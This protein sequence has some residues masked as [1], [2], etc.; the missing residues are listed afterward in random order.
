[1]IRSTE[2]PDDDSRSARKRR[3]ILDSAAELFLAN[4]YLGTSLDE[5][6]AAA[7]VSKQTVYKQFTNKEALFIGVVR[8]MTGEASDLV[9]KDMVA[10]E[11]FEQLQEQL[12]AYAERQLSVVMTPRLLQLRRLAIAEASR[13]PELGREV[14]DGGPGRAI[15]LLTLAFTRWAE[16]GLLREH[17]PAV[18]ASQFNWLVMAEPINRAMLLGNDAIPPPAEIRAHAE[19]AVATFLRAY[20]NHLS[21]AAVT[22]GEPKTARLPIPRVR[23]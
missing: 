19:H 3:A 14:F 16:A 17:D 13:F 5:V 22:Q 2:K 11:S 12:L 21:A 20:A 9:Q 23:N 8:S 4:G 10:P 1:M 18:A 7:S 15:N 6:A